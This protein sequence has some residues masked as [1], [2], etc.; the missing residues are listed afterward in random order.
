MSTSGT[1]TF[2]TTRN[3]LIRAAALEVSAI[4]AGITMSAEM[5][6]DFA[7][8]LNALIKHWQG[9]GLHI[10]TVREATLFP[11]PGQTRYGAGTG[12][13]D[14]ITETW[15]QTELSAN[16]AASAATL[17]VDST[18]DI[19][20]GHYIGVRLDSGAFHW[21][22]VQAKTASSVTLAV[23]LPSAAASGNTVVTYSTRIPKP[24]RIVGARVHNL[25]SGL[26]TPIDVISTQEYRDYPNKTSAG[27]IN[28]IQYDPQRLIGYVNLWAVPSV[29]TD[30]LKF[31][32]WRPVEIF[33]AG[34]D[35]PDLPEEWVNCLKWN[36]A[37]EMM[38][39]YPVNPQRRADIKENAA[40]SLFDMEGF[41]REDAS[42]FIQPRWRR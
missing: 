30:A 31:T 5:T 20:T 25:A 42:I 3:D 41:S 38:G 29:I 33:T 6:K 9:R 34:S 8:A 35:N 39:R 13:T 26:D 19:A 4:G 14:H 1:T 37:K 27:S 36:L 15:S 7:F 28:N 21:T 18:S 24:V 2:T 12:A 16:A 40:S 23:A 10:W 11:Q 22:T 32:Y 17:S